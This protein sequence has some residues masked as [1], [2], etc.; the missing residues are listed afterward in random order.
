MIH[1]MQVQLHDL[2]FFLCWYDQ[3]DTSLCWYVTSHSMSDNSSGSETNGLQ[4]DERQSPTQEKGFPHKN[5]ISRETWV[6]KV[7]VSENILG[8]SSVAL[9]TVSFIVL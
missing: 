5:K 8:Q 7:H 9:L 3:A 4:V 1:H 6:K 2:S